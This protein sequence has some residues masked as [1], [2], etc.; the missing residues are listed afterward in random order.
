MFS[1]SFYHFNC[2]CKLFVCFVSVCCFSTRLCQHWGLW[3]TEM[4]SSLCPVHMVELTMN[5]IFN[6]NL[7]YA[8]VCDRKR[9]LCVWRVDFKKHFN[10]A[11]FSVIIVLL[12]LVE[13]EALV[14]VVDTVAF[15]LSKYILINLTTI[16]YHMCIYLYK[17]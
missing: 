16:P 11:V 2:A 4:L 1:P 3:V 17:R 13:V 15:C 7:C 9:S 10:T 5:L 12:W 6:L 14:I 8:S